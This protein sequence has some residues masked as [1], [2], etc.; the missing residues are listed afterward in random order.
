[1][2]RY[3]DRVL[4]HVA[5]GRFGKGP[6]QGEHELDSLIRAV[7]EGIRSGKRTRQNIRTGEE[8]IGKQADEPAKDDKPERIIRFSK[9]AMA[10]GNKPAKHLTRKEAELVSHGWFKQYRGRAASRYRSTPPK[11]SLK[12]PGA[13]CQGRIDPS[14]GV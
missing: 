13:G 7:G 9:Q 6:H 1:M 8:V 5:Q 12:G 3:Q 11:Q 4:P 10:Q 14:R 2:E